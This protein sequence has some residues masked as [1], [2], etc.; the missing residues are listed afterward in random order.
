[1]EQPQARCW[2]DF[3]DLPVIPVAGGELARGVSRER[4]EKM[5][6]LF[7]LAWKTCVAVRAEVFL[8][9]SSCLS[10]II[11][12]G[13]HTHLLSGG[14]WRGERQPLHRK[15]AEH[16]CTNIWRTQ[17]FFFPSL[18]NPLPVFPFF[19]FPPLCSEGWEMPQECTCSLSFR[20]PALPVMY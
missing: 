15:S 17:F 3:P 5:V 20:R 12:C 14:C 2:Q 7:L 4:E 19:F 13:L 1:M 11:P 10:G 8:W 6:C 9:H 16:F 18:K